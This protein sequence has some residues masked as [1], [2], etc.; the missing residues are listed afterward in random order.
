M[1]RLRR[2]VPQVLRFGLVGAAATAVHSGVYLA[3]AQWLPPLAANTAGFAA[4]FSV[5]FLGHRWWTFAHSDVEWR[6]SLLKYLVTAL[7]G[8]ASNSLI[9]WILVVKW[10]QP[11]ATALWGI[12]LVTP[13]LVFVCSKWWAFALPASSGPAQAP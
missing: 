2:A 4:A 10:G 8:F 6:S 7:L 9:T 1:R 3:T 5:S 11:P 13:A 12:A